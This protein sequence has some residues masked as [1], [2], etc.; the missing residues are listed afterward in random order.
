MRICPVQQ[1]NQPHSE[2]LNAAQLAAVNQEVQR[3]IAGIKLRQWVVEQ[4]L[5]NGGANADPLRL[6]RELHAFI[7][8][9]AEPEED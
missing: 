9:T 3:V 6:A 1:T 2:H 4:V 5:V 7:I 8:G